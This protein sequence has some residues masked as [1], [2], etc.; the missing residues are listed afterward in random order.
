[1]KKLRKRFL[2]AAFILCLFLPQVAQAHPADMY[3]HTIAVNIS[4][5]DVRILWG[6]EPGP[7]VTHVIWQ[8]AENWIAPLVKSFSVILDETPLNLEIASLSW[9]DKLALMRA[10]D[11]KIL[12]EL[13]ADWPAYLGTPSMW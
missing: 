4:A 13:H 9:P 10:G 3:F 8:E 2:I 12:I 11:E 6:F 7:I 1:M 5:E